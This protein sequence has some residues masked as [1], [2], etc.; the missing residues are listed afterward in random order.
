MLKTENQ[1]NYPAREQSKQV[2][3]LAYIS[4]QFIHIPIQAKCITSYIS[5]KRRLCGEFLFFYICYTQETAP[6]VGG[7]VVASDNSIPIQSTE[8]RQQK[9]LPTICSRHRLPFPYPSLPSPLPR[10]ARASPHSSLQKPPRDIKKIVGKMKYHAW[11]HISNHRQQQQLRY[12]IPAPFFKALHTANRNR[13]NETPL[14]LTG[15]PA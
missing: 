14:L 10:R 8:V 12:S 9:S 11:H 5:Y 3:S 13:P 1:S 2:L 4:A 7:G 6:G 15:E